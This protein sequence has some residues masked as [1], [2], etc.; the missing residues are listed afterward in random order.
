MKMPSTSFRKLIEE[1]AESIWIGSAIYWLGEAKF[2]QDK[3]DEAFLY[4]RKVVT[5]YPES[6]FYAYALYSCGWVQ[7]EKGAFEE[8]YR[9]FHQVN[10][11]SPGHP[12]AESSLFWSAYCLYSLGRYAETE[13]ELEPLIQGHPGRWRPE[14]EYLMG[15]SY[16]RL[17]KFREAA[18]HFGGFWKRFPKHPLVES[19][20]YAFAWSLLSLGDCSGAR[21]TFEEILFAYPGTRFSD[22]IFWGIVK[23][24][25]GADEV[26]KAVHLHQSFLSQFLPSPWIEQCLFD[27]GQYYFEKKDYLRAGATFR[28]FLRTYPE[29]ELQEWVYFMLGES[30]LQ[31]EGLSRCDRRSYLQALE[32]KR[33]GE[34]RTPGFLEAGFRSF[35]QEELRACDSLLGKACLRFS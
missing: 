10:E 2:R 14:A 18:D 33:K 25:L 12:I 30:S 16:F 3:E 22:P 35:L 15:V 31:S 6:E 5:K 7:L 11:K 17:Q 29:S 8:G 19:A 34:A 4:F 26:E 27:I 24:Y 20:R 9:F 13:R 32:E 28:Q 23:T 1:Y 21:K